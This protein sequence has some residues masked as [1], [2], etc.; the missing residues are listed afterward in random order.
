MRPKSRASIR[1][2]RNRRDGM[3]VVELTETVSGAQ[4]QT[5]WRFLPKQKAIAFAEDLATSKRKGGWDVSIDV[6][7]L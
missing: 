5:K 1:I 6:P 2:P 7:T 4:I 3:W